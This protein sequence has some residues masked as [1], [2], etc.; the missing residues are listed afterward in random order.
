MKLNPLAFIHPLKELESNETCILN[1]TLLVH[2][3][4]V[5]KVLT[6]NYFFK[7]D[8]LVLYEDFC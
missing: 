2:V 7:I 4:L 6:Y 1:R 5:L 8:L 3:F